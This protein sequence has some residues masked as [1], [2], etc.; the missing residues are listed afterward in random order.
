MSEHLPHHEQHEKFEAKPDTEPRREAAP[1]HQPRH[2]KKLEP[3]EKLAQHAKEEAVVG[4][5]LVGHEKQRPAQSDLYVTKELKQQTWN[6]SMTRVRKHLSTP[7]KAFSKVIH[8]PVVDS[9]SRVSEKTVARPSGFLMGSIFAFLGSSVFL[10]V[11]RHYGF[12]YNYLLF[13]L[14]FIVGFA[15]GLLVEALLRVL[16]KSK[17]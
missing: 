17:A 3:V 7:S 2:E 16:H 6:R 8:Q 1:E 9:V 11:S 4:K 10:W 5:D 15:V 12:T 13:F 14:F